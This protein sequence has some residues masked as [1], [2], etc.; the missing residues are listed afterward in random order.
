MFRGSNEINMDAKGRMAIPARYKDALAAD[1]DGRLVITIDVTDKCLLVYPLPEWEK[2]EDEIR[3]LSTLNATSRRMQRLLIGH[4]RDLEMDATGRILI[5]PELRAFAELE[6]KVTL[7]GQGHRLELWNS[8]SWNNQR[9]VW[10]SE[11]ASE[12]DIPAELQTLSL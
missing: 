5:P 11:E 9:E 12:M 3:V 7:V 10:L 2:K 8:L 4:A 1:C 6:K